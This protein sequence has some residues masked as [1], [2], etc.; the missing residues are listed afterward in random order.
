MLT[1]TTAN[2]PSPQQFASCVFPGKGHRI[3]NETTCRL[4]PFNLLQLPFPLPLSNP[5]TFMFSL[6][7]C[8]SITSKFLRRCNLVG[9]RA[10]ALAVLSRT[11]KRLDHLGLDE[12][13]IEL[14]QLGEPEI[15]TVKTVIGRVV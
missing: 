5:F 10:E 15:V 14:V 11:E 13:A 2:N 7:T 9:S 6:S 1:E 4:L 12:V 3:D 8:R